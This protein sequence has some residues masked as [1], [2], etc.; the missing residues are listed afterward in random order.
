MPLV[1]AKCRYPAAWALVRYGDCTQGTARPSPLSGTAAACLPDSCST[2]DLYSHEIPKALAPRSRDLL[3]AGSR[4]GGCLQFS[5]Q[6]R[7]H[8]RAD[9]EPEHEGVSLQD[10]PRDKLLLVT[11]EITGG[12]RFRRWQD[13]WRNVASTKHDHDQPAACSK[14]HAGVTQAYATKF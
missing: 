6:R 13:L 14:R 11:D 7:D 12:S 2:F 9:H 10:H 1:V 8:H 4:K 3:P 5:I